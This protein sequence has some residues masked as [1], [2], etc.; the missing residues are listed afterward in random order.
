M[1]GKKLMAWVLSFVL[2]VPVTYVI[3]LLTDVPFF[4]S[5]STLY[6][7]LSI[8]MLAA[9]FSYIIDTFMGAELYDEHGWHL[10]IVEPMGPLVNDD[11]PPP[12]DYEPIPSRE[13]RLKRQSQAR[14]GN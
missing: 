9:F 7:V 2:A 14:Q 12:A 8:L 3:F 1:N 5:V 11:P 4:S 10:G 6:T 13:E